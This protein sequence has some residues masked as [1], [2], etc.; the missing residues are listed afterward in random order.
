[1]KNDEPLL[2]EIEFN[3]RGS[4]QCKLSLFKGND[5]LTVFL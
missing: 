2:L 3:K 5:I 4:F 1:M